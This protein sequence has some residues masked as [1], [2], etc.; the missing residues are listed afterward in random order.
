MFQ[1]HSVLW[2][3]LWLAPSLL[4]L[5]LVFGFWRRRIHKEHPFFVAFA[6]ASAGEQLILYVLDLSPSVSAL[7]WWRFFWVGLSIEGILKFLLVGEIFAHIFHP[8]GAL[9]KLGKRLIGGSGII[10]VFAA[11]L[12]AAITP[13]D[14]AFGIVSGVH[15]LEQSVYIIECGL[16]ASM[17]ALTAYFHIRMPHRDAFIALGLGIS[18]C[19]HLATWA[20]A[21][22]NALPPEG[23]LI[24][25]VINMA[26]FHVCVLVW[27]YVLLPAKT[28]APSIINLPE[29]HLD[30]WNREL[31]RLLQ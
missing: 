16:L 24:L 18:A 5:I 28:V 9:A 25:D 8:Y 26:T 17:F 7:N 11:A 12:A 3:Y 19:V 10:L 21:A 4:L 15:V 30:L 1:A 6:L 14:S 13:A 27:L 29:N 2:H 31:E 22:N 23:R 20:V